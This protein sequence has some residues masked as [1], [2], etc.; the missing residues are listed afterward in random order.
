MAF[1]SD[2]DIARAGANVHQECPLV[3]REALSSLKKKLADVV[4]KRD[5]GSSGGRKE[6]R[7]AANA[8]S[9]VLNVGNFQPRSILHSDTRT[10]SAA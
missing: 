5:R 7:Q 8:I 2:L 1:P 3:G 10:I 9:S 6:H 4:Q